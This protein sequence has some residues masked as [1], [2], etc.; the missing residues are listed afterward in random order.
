[1]IDADKGSENDFKYLAICQVGGMLS[2]S[3]I[4]TVFALALGNALLESTHSS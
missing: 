1:M 3:P 4:K 2:K